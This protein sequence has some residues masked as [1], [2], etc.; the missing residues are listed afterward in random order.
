MRLTRYVRVTKK[1]TCSA[2]RTSHANS[3]PGTRISQREE[4][5]LNKN[6][7]L[8]SARAA[9]ATAYSY[10]SCRR[11]MASARTKHA[12]APT[13]SPANAGGTSRS[14]QDRPAILAGTHTRSPP[15]T[16]SPPRR[17]PPGTTRRRPPAR[18]TPRTP[19][20]PAC[21]PT[22][23]RAATPAPSAAARRPAPPPADASTLS[24]RPVDRREPRGFGYMGVESGEVGW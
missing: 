15:G 4:K 23:P 10:S 2:S 7:S 18:T 9:P 11:P 16:P 22:P 14:A 12:E 24:R 8:R 17:R 20:A 21:P 5:K 19:P 6:R 13:A 1:K 3:Q